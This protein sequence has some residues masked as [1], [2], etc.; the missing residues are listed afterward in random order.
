MLQP[1]R[2]WLIC[3][4]FSNASCS[5]DKWAAA[6]YKAHKG[7][8][9]LCCRCNTTSRPPTRG[10]GS[11]PLLQRSAA[12]PHPLQPQPHLRALEDAVAEAEPHVLH[13]L[14]ARG[15]QRLQLLHLQRAVG[16]VVRG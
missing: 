10:R 1:C 8:V 7:S 11:D 2:T 14:L 4:H 15:Q 16:C 5:M 9:L 3:S 12:A 6:V 13:L